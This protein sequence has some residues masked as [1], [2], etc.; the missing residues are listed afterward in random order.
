M[1]IAL[2]W[3]I[4]WKLKH[5]F[6]CLPSSALTL[7]TTMI[8]FRPHQL[9]VEVHLN[10]LIL[11]VTNNFVADNTDNRSI[12]TINHS[13]RQWLPR[14]KMRST[15]QHKLTWLRRQL[16]Y[17]RQN[18][19]QLC[20]TFRLPFYFVAHTTNFLSQSIQTVHTHNSFRRRRHQTVG[21][22]QQQQQK[23]PL[24]PE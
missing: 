16:W 6:L 12:S 23:P 8:V 20:I 17:S 19:H 15:T 2:L 1:H 21:A 18:F 10:L 22:T 14:N 3:L 4:E 11:S 24:M 9:I 7:E 13:N 5:K